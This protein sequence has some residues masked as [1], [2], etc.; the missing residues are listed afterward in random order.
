[1]TANQIAYA[2]YVE[3]NR[4]NLA[5]ESETSKHN[6]TTEDVAYKNWSEVV[7]HNKV[8]EG[9]THRH[10]VQN[11][12][13][14][15][16]T[17]N[18]NIRHNKRSETISDK[19]ANAAL[20]QA[21]TADYNA[22]T[23]RLY[24]QA[25][26]YEAEERGGLFTVQA[27]ESRAKRRATEAGIEKTQ[28]ELFW[29]NAR[30]TAGIFKDIGSLFTGSAKKTGSTSKGSSVTKGSTKSAKPQNSAKTSGKSKK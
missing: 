8:G 14:N 18:E 9:E 4:H 2:N 11:E 3:S 25:K 6:R 7:R 16:G 1:M 30:N 24:K 21:R 13:F 5:S 20:S 23:D 12:L 29:N 22:T 19:Q 27:D 28:N 10:N 26:S 15:I 17:L